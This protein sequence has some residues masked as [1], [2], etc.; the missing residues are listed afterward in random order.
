MSLGANM[1]QQQST[2]RR[3]RGGLSYANVD[4]ITAI[5]IFLIGGV[6]MYDNYRIGVSWAVDGPEAGYFP[7]YIGVI[8]CLASIAVLLK[9]L[10]GKARNHD[11]FVTWD[12]LRLVLM[13]LAPTAIYVLV[14]QFLGIYVASTLFIG[15]FMRVLGKISWVKTVLV[16]VLVSVL[17]FWMFEVEFMVPLPKGPLEAYFGY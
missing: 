4:A 7:F 9:S 6:M 17:L 13:V 1:Q 16:S 5:V 12:R 11:V 2:A 15:V 3:T 8:L 10:L 14:I